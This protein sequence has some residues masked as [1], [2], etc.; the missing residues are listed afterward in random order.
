MAL[1]KC[2]ECAAEISDKA[3]ACPKCGNPIGRSSP[4]IEPAYVHAPPPEK[5]SSGWLKWVVIVPVVLFGLLMLVGKASDPDGAVAAARL[6]SQKRECAEA[7]ASSIGHSTVGYADK[8]AY[9]AQVRE[10]CD[11]LTI[12][13]KPIGQ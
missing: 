7:L 8:A 2:G 13:G 9:D 3:A 11:G 6:E 4:H 5:K 10:K 1:I 12:D